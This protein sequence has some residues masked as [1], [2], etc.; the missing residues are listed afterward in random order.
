MTSVDKHPLPCP[1][2]PCYLRSNPA[3]DRKGAGSGLAAKRRKIRR[4]EGDLARPISLQR[5]SSTAAIGNVRKPWDYSSFSF[6]RIL[7]LFAATQFP[8]LG[9]SHT[10]SNSEAGFSREKAQDTQK[11]RGPSTATSLQLSSSAAAIGN[12]RKAW[13]QPSFSFL[14]ILRLFAANVSCPAGPG[15][16]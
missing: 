10:R 1:R 4:K 2:S 15:A 5:S 14:R 8:L 7:R 13:D 16:L 11:R 9:C 6:L 3:S 12:D